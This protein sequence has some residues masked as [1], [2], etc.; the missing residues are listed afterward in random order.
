[1]SLKVLSEFLFSFCVCYTLVGLTPPPKQRPTQYE[2]AVLRIGD[3]TY[4]SHET[5]KPDEIFRFKKD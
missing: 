1:M 2:S 5:I 4:M 3:T